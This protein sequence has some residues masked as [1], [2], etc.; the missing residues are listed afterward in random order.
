M[1]NLT[2]SGI[3]APGD[4]PIAETWRTETVS[5]CTVVS[6]KLVSQFQIKTT[7]DFV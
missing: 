5:V 4:G 6:G 3:C 1:Y 7:M 2:P